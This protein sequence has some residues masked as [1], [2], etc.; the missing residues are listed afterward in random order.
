M[1][2]ELSFKIVV[3]FFGGRDDLEALA[4]GMRMME[5]PG[6]SLSLVKFVGPP[7]KLVS[8]GNGGDGGAK[9]PQNPKGTDDNNND[10]EAFFTECVSM[11]KNQA[12]A[13]YEEREVGNKADI[14]EA[15]KTISK[16]CSLFLVGRMPACVPQL[17]EASDCAELGPV[18]SLMA[19]S[20]FSSTVSV[21]VVQQYDPS[22]ATL[23]PD[24]IEDQGGEDLPPDTPVAGAVPEGV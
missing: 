18:G 6:I 24:V 20:D 21:L 5:H 19:S 16:S 15:L 4:Y 13:S 23:N 12:D 11:I 3:P 1:A 14:N 9:S 10:D 2:S 17:V 8:G 7:W 22:T